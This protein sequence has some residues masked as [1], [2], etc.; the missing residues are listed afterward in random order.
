MDQAKFVLTV[1]T[2]DEEG[3]TS[4]EFTNIND[5]CVVFYQLDQELPENHCILLERCATK[6]SSCSKFEQ[7]EQTLR[8]E[9]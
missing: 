2:T 4:Q 1:F 9:E 5:A 6:I 8:G 3:C 7:G